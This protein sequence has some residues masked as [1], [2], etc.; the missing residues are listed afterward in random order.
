MKRIARSEEAFKH[1]GVWV[2]QHKKAR[3]QRRQKA[4][5]LLQVKYYASKISH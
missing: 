3:E 1:Q 2:E 4:N 5:D